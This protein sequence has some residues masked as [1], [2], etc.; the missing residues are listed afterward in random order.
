MFDA[1]KLLIVSVATVVFSYLQPLHNLMQV[2]L[3]LYFADIVIGI[4]ADI[5]V[6]KQRLSVRKLLYALLC[7]AIYLFVIIMFYT[8]GE[9]MGDE[10]EFLLIN[11]II[12]YVLI[13]FYV[14]NVFKNL[15]ILFPKNRAI[16]FL[17]FAIG[18]QFAGKIPHLGYFLENEKKEKENENN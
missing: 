17:D 5:I 8:I 12:T 18:L 6:N 15:R 10:S 4:F 2:L 1:L 16:A 11:K 7:F 14:S 3:F 13:Y 9:K